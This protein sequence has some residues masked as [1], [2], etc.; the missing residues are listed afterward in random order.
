MH[1]VLITRPLSIMNYICNY[2]LAKKESLTLAKLPGL[3]LPTFLPINM[4]SE[5]SLIYVIME[6]ALSGLDQRYEVAH[7]FMGEGFNTHSS[8]G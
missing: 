3:T 1:L 7:P 8:Y 6:E 2:A 4:V 5:F